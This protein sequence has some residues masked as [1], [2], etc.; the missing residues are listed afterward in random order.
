MIRLRAIGYGRKYYV[1]TAEGAAELARS[2][3]A[4]HALTATVNGRIART[5]SRLVPDDGPSLP[6]AKEPR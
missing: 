4:W 1:P 5:T 2:E 3:R 6:T